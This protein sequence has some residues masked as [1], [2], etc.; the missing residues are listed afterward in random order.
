MD[1]TKNKYFIA[2]NYTNAD[3]AGYVSLTADETI[4]GIKTFSSSL[5]ISSVT[6]STSSTTGAL[7]C[8]GGAYF[9]A[10]CL[11][12]S[13][14]ITLTNGVFTSTA[15]GSATA[16]AFSVGGANTGLYASVA[17]VLNFSAGGASRMQ[18]STAS[19]QTQLPLRLAINGTAV[20]PALSFTGDT[21]NDSGFYLIGDNNIGVSAGGV[22]R[23]DWNS[24][25]INST[26]SLV[27]PSGSLG[28]PSLVVGSSSD[29]GIFSSLP[30]A[31]NFAIAG[32]NRVQFSSNS[33]FSSVPLSLG[34]GSASA[35]SVAFTND[36][37]DSG[38]YLI[39]TDNIGFSSGGVLRFD[40]NNSR[41]NSAV[42]IYLPNGSAS[43][44]SLSFGSDGGPNTGLYWV[45]DDVIGVSCGGNRIMGLESSAQYF[46]ATTGGV[47]RFFFNSN[48]TAGDVLQFYQTRG[49]TANYFFYSTGGTYGTVSDRKLKKNIQA[50]DNRK[51]TALLKKLSPKKYEWVDQD[52]GPTING[53]IA[54]DV[55][56][57]ADEIGEFTELVSESE[58][59][60]RIAH[61]QLIMVL[62]SAMIDIIE[63][64]EK[65][66][67]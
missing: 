47:Q 5:R 15:L 31:I 38:M 60:L 45:S 33:L 66:N 63:R 39:G 56:E 58:G 3:A 50:L 35:P 13:G 7:Q 36:S 53:L 9:G 21:S 23:W 49:S 40:Y 37:Q 27:L 25:R 29:T 55:K 59:T 43:A 8:A 12:G 10:S 67:G 46:Y 22:L 17:G 6:P 44:P 20:A 24:S 48:T 54:Q 42:P 14:N 51:A 18:I 19:I 61:D 57:A 1:L 30:G 64:L 52:K 32:V 2:K 11:F 65:K 26:I 34:S 62:T 16:T 41:I 28:S 4:A